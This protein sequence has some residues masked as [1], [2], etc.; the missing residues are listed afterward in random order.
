LLLITS[1]IKIICCI[2]KKLNIKTPRIT[3][4][5]M[6]LE[7]RVINIQDAPAINRLSDQLGYPLSIEQTLQNLEAIID[8]SEHAAFAAINNGELVGWIGV[9]RIIMIEMMPYCEINGLVVD[10]TFHGNGIGKL[11]IEEAKQW[12][13]L[14]RNDKLRL[15]CNV[16]RK[17]AHQF[18]SHLG[19][20]AT[21]QQTN[22][23]IDI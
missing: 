21:K 18:Y 5:K 20:V 12:A 22:F 16:V 3:I 14:K 4:L 10:E 11:L 15:R 17:D 8:S 9:A 19:F 2:N 7:I 6:N 13:R 23:E 1:E